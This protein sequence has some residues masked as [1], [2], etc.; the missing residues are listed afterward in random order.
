MSQ[1][2]RLLIAFLAAFC[3]VT[4]AKYV[5]GISYID[6]VQLSYNNGTWQCDR[7]TC[8]ARAHGCKITIRNNPNNESELIRSSACYTKEGVSMRQLSQTQRM[9]KPKTV[10]ID[11]DSYVGAQSVYTS[12]Y[13]LSWQEVKGTIAAEDWP[14]AQKDTRASMKAVDE[15]HG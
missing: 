12:A 9:L 8:K 14:N 3:Y 10:N 6:D 5:P 11:V 4:T 7:I 15:S 1:L 13:S 2:A